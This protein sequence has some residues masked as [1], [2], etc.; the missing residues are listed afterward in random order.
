VQVQRL[1][2]ILQVVFQFKAFSAADTGPEGQPIA[3]NNL[4]H[5]PI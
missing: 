2:M 5:L 4:G 3:F 1:N